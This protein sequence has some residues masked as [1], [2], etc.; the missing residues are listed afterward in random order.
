MSNIS[1]RRSIEKIA[2]TSFKKFTLS[3]CVMDDPE[4]RFIF[5]IVITYNYIYTIWRKFSRNNLRNLFI[6]SASDSAW[7]ICVTNIGRV[8]DLQI[9]QTSKLKGWLAYAHSNVNRLIFVSHYDRQK[10]GEIFWIICRAQTTNHANKV[11]Q[12]IWL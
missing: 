12:A 10:S 2:V 8:R 11:H 9:T 4:S 7:I 6:L 3:L 1:S 5:I